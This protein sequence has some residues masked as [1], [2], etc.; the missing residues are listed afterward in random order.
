MVQLNI[1][2]YLSKEMKANIRRAQNICTR[3]KYGL[4]SLILVSGLFW[5][6]VIVILAQNRPEMVRFFFDL[7]SNF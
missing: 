4:I 3:P 7:I 5:L 1:I 2:I 6:G